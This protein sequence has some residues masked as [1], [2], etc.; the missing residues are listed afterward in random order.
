L[1]YIGDDV[2]EKVA[3][4]RYLGWI[5]LQDDDGI[6]AVRIQIKKARG[7]W[8]RVSQILRADNT[9]PKISAMF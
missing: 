3:T 7:I 1:F 2:L 5:L 8:A 6:R 9:P 4:L